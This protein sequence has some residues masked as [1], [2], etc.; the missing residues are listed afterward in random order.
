MTGWNVADVISKMDSTNTNVTALVSLV[1]GQNKIGI[2]PALNQM[3]MDLF[4][5]LK[6]SGLNFTIKERE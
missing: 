5:T 4:L 3:P 6:R 2:T 1:K